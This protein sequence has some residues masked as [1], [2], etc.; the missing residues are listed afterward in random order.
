[1]KLDLH[2][3]IAVC[4]A[5]SVG[6]WLLATVDWLLVRLEV[7]VY[8]QPEVARKEKATEDSGVLSASAVAQV[9]EVGPASSSEV[10][11]G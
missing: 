10:R 3:S 4:H 9:G 6:D 1:M 8:E 11:V 5:F 2:M 7:K